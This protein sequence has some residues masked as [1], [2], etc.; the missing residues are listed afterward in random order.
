MNWLISLLQL[1]SLRPKL[2]SRNFAK[3]SIDPFKG[4]RKIPESVRVTI[5]FGKRDWLLPPAARQR[6]E[7]PE[8]VIW[9][10]RKGWGHVPMWDDPE[11]VAKFILEG[12]A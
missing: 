9:Q 1:Q 4:G 10:D 8:D 12:I 6:H 11:E 7:I 5:A 3:V 2:T